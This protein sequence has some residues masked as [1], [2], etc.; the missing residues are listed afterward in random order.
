MKSFLP[1]GSTLTGLLLPELISASRC[2]ALV[3]SLEAR[4]FEKT[5]T[6]YPP[7]YRDNDRLVF[8][9]AALSTWLFEQARDSLPA[10]LEIEGTRWKLAGLNTRFRA[11]RYESGQSF[12]IHR[13]G[14]YT[15]SP[16]TRSW[17]TLQVYLND[18]TGFEGG[19]TRFY[20]DAHGAKPLS[21]VTAHR[22]TGIVF[23][24]RFWHDGEAVSSGIKWVVRTDVMYERADA[25]SVTKR[26]PD[27]IG[28][29]DGYAWRAI[30]CRGGF[31]ASAGR[32]GTLRRWFDDGR[33]P[34]I[35]RVAKGSVTALC[36]DHDG[37]LWFGTREG[38]ISRGT[39]T[40]QLGSAI[41]SLACTAR[42][43]IIATTA[44]GELINVNQHTTKRLHE[45]WAWS[46]VSVGDSFITCGQ[47]GKLITTT[48]D[49]VSRTLATFDH[50]LRALSADRSTHVLAGDLTGAVHRVDLHTG[51][52]VSSFKA[53][54]AAVTSLCVRGARWASASE[55]GTAKLFEHERV[56]HE[57]RSTDFMSSVDIEA[58]TGRFIATGY[59]GLVR[60]IA[61]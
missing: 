56:I 28:R 34:T 15:P 12:C 26:D 51:E 40:L 55:D 7:G 53:H 60:A 6:A 23:D 2:E 20:E 5:A 41:L 33:A 19:K 44:G 13:D 25:A 14:A 10:V 11:C 29:H 17:L 54:E 43:E 36:E 3:Q 48:H 50:P 61:P 35:N 30:A 4:G 21:E 1:D 37:Q 58:T 31:I 9:D 42:G 45:A 38:L 47:D 57:F 32:D 59:D 27:V 49:G 46:V 16:T 52:L 39:Q 8:D 22:G 24:H 18:A